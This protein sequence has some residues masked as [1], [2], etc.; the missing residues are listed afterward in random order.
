MGSTQLNYGRE[1]FSRQDR[2]KD[3]ISESENI[4]EKY[5]CFN[6]ITNGDFSKEIYSVKNFLDTKI[7]FVESIFKMYNRKLVG[8]IS[9]SSYYLY[10]VITRI[11]KYEKTKTLLSKILCIA[12][13]DYV[14]LWH[15]LEEILLTLSIEY[16]EYGFKRYT[17]DQDPL[18][19]FKYIVCTTD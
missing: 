15:S 9:G 19:Y 14:P 17:I 4:Y 1:I 3:Y 11:L 6:D 2:P 10:F 18:T 16:E 13:L 8:G 12:V 5:P 7:T